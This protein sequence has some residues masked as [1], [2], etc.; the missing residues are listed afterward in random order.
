MPPSVRLAA[1]YASGFTELVEKKKTTSAVQG[2]PKLKRQ[3]GVDEICNIFI[4]DLPTTTSTLF[5]KFT[6]AQR[7][8]LFPNLNYSG[9][10]YGIVHLLEVFPLLTSDQDAIGEGI[11]G[12][13]KSLYFF[14]DREC[15]DQL[16]YLIA[17]Q[18][19][20]MPVEMNKKLVWFLADCILPYTMS[21]EALGG[22]SVAC[23]L[24]LVFQQYN[25]PSLHTYILE[26][27]M[28]HR[29]DMYND[30]IAVIAKGTSEARVAAANL[31]FH[32]WPLINPSILHRKPIQYKVHAWSP[33]PCEFGKVNKCGNPSVKITYDP[34]LCANFGST[35]PPM[36][37]CKGCADEAV[38]DQ[39][40]FFITQPMPASNSTV[41]QHKACE[42]TNRFAVGTCFAE[43]CIRSHQHVPM[44][45]CQECLT[46]LHSN[47]VAEK[48]VRHKRLTCA[49]GS[50]VEL[51]MIEA[52]VKLL[53]ETS[54]Q[55]EG[56]EGELKRPKWLRQLEG[57]Q[58]LGRDIDNMADEKRMLSR[59]GIWLMA[60][61]C[62]PTTEAPSAAIGYMM[63][64]VFQWFT[65]TALLPNDSMGSALERLKTDFASEWVNQAI[66]NHYDT[67]VITLM[68]KM[69]EYAQVGGVWDKWSNRKDQLKEG[70][71]KLLALMPYDVISFDTWNQV[72][73]AWL[74]CISEQVED[75]DLAE[76]K[77]L[78]CKI[79]EPDLCPLP[80]E[81]ERVF[82]FISIR[83]N[84]GSYEDILDALDWLNL[85]CRM[86]ITV[87]LTM[88]LS[89]F[90]NCLTR[91]NEIAPPPSN[92]ENDLEEDPG[93]LAVQVIMISIISQQM[94]LNETTQSEKPALMEQLFAT[95][96]LLL[97]YP[98]NAK[99]DDHSCQ[100]PETDQYSD[101]VRCQQAS[102]LYQ[103]VNA[104][105]EQLCP[106][107][108][109]KF[110]IMPIEEDNWI[111]DLQMT[112]SGTTPSHI[113]NITSPRNPSLHASI[114]SPAVSGG[115]QQISSAKNGGSA[116]QFRTANVQEEIADDEF[117]GVLPSEE[118]ETAVA[119]AVTLTETDV[120]RETCQIVT[121]TLF[122]NLK[123][124]PMQPREQAK[125]EF[126]N[127]SIGRFRFT[128]DQL[129]AQLRLIYSLMQNVEN[130]V[131]PDVQYFLLSTMKYLCLHCE[132]LSNARRE[133]R[134]F[135]IWAQE[136]LLI[137]K[138]WSLLRSDY[139]QVG[140]L[141]VPLIIHAIT[142]PCGDEVFWNT[143]NR[144][145]TSERWED[146]FKSVERVY[147]LAHMIV[148]APV[149]ANKLL[150]TSLSCAFSHLI[151]SVN[152][153]NTAVAQRTI[154]ALRSM[155]S[156]ALSLINICLEAQFDSCIIDRPLIISRIYWLTSVVPEE[157]ILSWE[158]FINRFETLAVEA[159]LKY[160]SG[161][162]GYVQGF[163]NPDPMSETNQ[164]KLS[165]ARQSLNEA[166]SVRSI[167]KSLRENSLKHQLTT[168]ARVER[169]DLNNDASMS[170]GRGT[171]AAA[172]GYGRLRE[173]TDEESNLSLLLN[174][175]VDMEN[176]ERH[177]VYLT[178]SL[179][180]HFL[181]NRKSNPSAEKNSAKK[182]SLLLRYFNTLLGYSNSEKC[183]TIPPD[184]LR[185]AA[186]CN[187][188]LS[189][190][191]EILDHNLMI[192]NQMLPIVAQLLVHLPSP[193]KFASDQSTADYSLSLMDLPARHS[194]LHTLIIIL[195]KYRYDVAPINDTI[196]KLIQIV[197]ATVE[198]Q[199][200]D[201]SNTTVEPKPTEFV[202]WSDSEDD[203]EVEEKVIKEEE[204]DGMCEQVKISAPVDMSSQM[205][206]PESLKVMHANSSGGQLI[207]FNTTEMKPSL[208][209][210]SMSQPTI[211]EPTIVLHESV[212]ES[213]PIPSISKTHYNSSRRNKFRNR[214]KKRQVRGEYVRLTCG[215]C[216]DALE[217]FDEETISLSLICLS[218][219]VHR[220][221]AMAAP[222]LFRIITSV[223][224]FVDSAQFPWHD[225]SIFVPGNSR[226]AAK[227]LLRVTLHQMSAC[228]IALQLFDSK[229]DKVNSFWQTV[230]FSLMDFSELNP[231]ALIQCLIED[232][233]EIWPQKLARIL[234]NLA[235]YITNT[236]KDTCQTNWS[237]VV[238]HLETLFRRYHSTLTAEGNNKV[239]IT[240]ELK[241]S[242]VIMSNIMRMQMFSSLKSCVSCV[243]AYSKWMTEALH[244]CPV[245][246]K[247]LL[248]ASCACIRGSVR[249]RDKQCINRAVVNELIQAI[250]FKCE[251]VE[252]NYL[253]IVNFVLQDYGVDVGTDVSQFNT[254]ASEA[255]RP[256][257]SDI[258]EFIA[259]LHVLS[260]LKKQTNSDR[261][262]GDLKAGLA[263]IVALEMTRNVVRD[264]NIQQV[265]RFIPWLMSP[266]NVTQAVPGAFAESV[267]NVRI[268]SW[269]L[270]G[271]LHCSHEC[272]PVPIDC[273]NH[274]ADYIHFVLAG[275][276]DQSKVD[277][278][279][280][281][282]T[283]NANSHSNH[284]S[285]Q[286]SV[287][288]MSALFHAFHLCQL[289]TVYCEKVSTSGKPGCEKAIENILDFWSRV[290]P[291]IL[292]L[293][294]HS[295]VLADMVN[296]HFVNTMQALQQCNS[297]ILCQCYPMWQPIL[298]AY[299]NQI[300]SQ[301]RMK[302]EACENQPSIENQPLSPWLKKVRYKIS[303][304]ELQT[305]AASPFYNV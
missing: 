33:T 29:Q 208:G 212:S 181:C 232:V 254:G 106:R 265:M 305:S 8:N 172:G 1:P 272:R 274:M 257:M 57:G 108:E 195:Y 182:Q 37:M 188:F 281:R 24:M 35:S 171:K 124:T 158:F 302:L 138:L 210:V 93:P 150:Q 31:L 72:I 34:V 252:S 58:S 127:T 185:K 297:A 146:R 26:N 268:L 55:L 164:I 167:V 126:W 4:K 102:Y 28:V 82:E 287:V 201:C 228:S 129:P 277:H 104:L 161:E 133:H 255:I 176:P 288:H 189:G 291:A 184:R 131:D 304:I 151:V 92:K 206:R 98:T 45:L 76:L 111:N 204:D 136:N 143:V 276:A 15:I 71:S 211:V 2:P 61:L 300:P 258:L 175:V 139:A 216:N 259:D 144:S 192:G 269:L 142:L 125:T 120:G 278:E 101:C 74:K 286:Q 275:F 241:S 202:L 283:L 220:E 237:N 224:R 109:V 209:E 169:V 301:L 233:L 121:A 51:D 266:P 155:P 239:P 73:P 153:P 263:Q 203:D 75:E 282:L 97:N 115:D 147:V 230:N 242:V 273:S 280:F 243:E 27:L 264:R 246:L 227:Q 88:I 137:P 293:L 16:P 83:L 200:H 48:H 11:I 132:A 279:H 163:A 59:Y 68:P 251:L 213:S 60:A 77:I 152:D 295:K 50:S 84:S 222:L 117:V 135:L 118:I 260:K 219:F 105:V 289:W 94:K 7:A 160:Q 65:M 214:N 165:R 25:D 229:I 194:W 187:A 256:F 20:I 248:E 170:T 66:S 191:P 41:C 154:M 174:R 79:F 36:K 13:L 5:Q 47:D 3:N 149:K 179:L 157:H 217:T 218:T 42:S 38:S 186:I 53:K 14:L 183:F 193:Q 250:K 145:F 21:E 205:I 95:A 44:R 199:C 261:V 114:V 86:D 168:S 223:A 87:S 159:Q 226:S 9:L 23:V 162:H 113:S 234:H 81:T 178:V 64:M 43:D 123:G 290:T 173:F 49:W 96:S 12:V 299:H 56:S 253:T 17:S 40:M 103:I 107:E 156:K 207:T 130:E 285:L 236:P 238:N 245:D 22:S 78:L 244:E 112:D 30:V 140:Q 262:G 296:L 298:T 70:L 196:L 225:Y 18:L 303:Q 221:P 292:Q 122:E 249:E 180:V 54:C 148:E 62:P 198:C 197:I 119:Q 116:F 90:Q 63:S 235:S 141:A 67:F 270:L 32:Y 39:P 240:S 267:T 85:L 215:F 91:V 190:L 19:G 134:G 99:R 247:D 100:N 6:E 10:F 80:F 166:E 46:C 284:N 69:P 110:D 89:M 271:A 231:V 128:L 177:T 52:V 294:S